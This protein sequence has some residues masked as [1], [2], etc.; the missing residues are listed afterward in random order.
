MMVLLLVYSEMNLCHLSCAVRVDKQ[1]EWLD[2]IGKNMLIFHN[3]VTCYACAEK[4]M[5]AIIKESDAFFFG[6]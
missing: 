1:D 3:G 5:C 2:Q 4:S 6:S